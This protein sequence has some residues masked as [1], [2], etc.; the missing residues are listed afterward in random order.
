MSTLLSIASS[1]EL[2]PRTGTNR[3]I[4]ALAELSPL[5]AAWLAPHLESREMTQGEMLAPAGEPFQHVYFPETAVMSVI[6]RM[7]NGDAAEVG[8]VGNEGMVGIGVFLGAIPSPHETVVQVAGA[9]LRV[10][11][12]VLADGASHPVLRRLLHQYTQE[13]LT[14][15]SQTA[16]CNRLHAIEPRCARWL[17]MTHDRVGGAMQF[18]LTQEYLA[19]MLG[20]RRGGVTVAAGALQ[21]AGLIRYRRGGIRVLDRPGLEAAA[22]ECYGIVRQH[23]DRVLN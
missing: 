8:T 20:V 19:V 17:L 15:V 23:F 3:I 12:A 13:Y 2:T 22:C 5:E 1:P 7:S 21:D 18:A 14:Q 10:S 16:A 6:S 9:S 4:A 11:A